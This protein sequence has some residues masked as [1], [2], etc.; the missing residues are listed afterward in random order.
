MRIIFRASASKEIGSGHIMRCLTLAE[1][2]CKKDGVS[3]EF[4]TQKYSEN[5]DDFIKKKGFN[6]HSLEVSKNRKVGDK[7]NH[8]FDQE[9]DANNTIK[10][11]KG[12]VIDWIIIDHYGI[13]YNWQEKIRP[14][15]KK[16]MVIDDLANRSHDCD[17]LLDQNYINNQARYDNLVSPDTIK[18]LGPRYAL[19]RKDFF[20]FSKKNTKNRIEV[21]K[22][23]IFFGGSDLDN[24]TSSSLK[25][26][27]QPDFQYLNLAVVIGSLN[28]H[29]EE[30]KYLVSENSNAKLYIQVEDIASLMS[31]ADIALGAGGSSTWERISVGLPSVVVTISEN[32]DELTSD[33][34]KDGYIKWLGSTDEVNERII[35]NAL[36]HAIQNPQKLEF[37]SEKCKALVDGLGAKRVSNLLLYGIETQGLFL[38]DANNKDCQLY[39]YWANDPLVRANA[40]N[41]EYI[42]LKNH[43]TWFKK[44]LEDPDVIM[45]V[46][47]SE[48]GPLGQVRFD[49]INSNLVLSYSISKNYRGFGLGKTIIAKAIEHLPGHKSLTI[50]AEV[51]EKNL[52]SRKIFENVGFSEVGK[53]HK[54]NQQIHT[55]HLQ[56]SPNIIH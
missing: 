23:F 53:S 24:L 49:S 20:E 16:I 13:D 25:A 3:V 6:V 46:I 19:L 18:L 42:E 5:L 55:Y 31:E 54:Y 22:V 2:F 48:F 50:I 43:E 9:Q 39:W 28:P 52:S 27:S 35:Q 17:L 51:K 36:K 33:L 7:E 56:I 32:Q 4:V 40:F 21:K 11:I 15:T 37:Q 1:S 8:T 29:K 47:D 10:A 38:R 44:R 45:L 14:Y 12:N 34:D 26:L 41:Q 30:I